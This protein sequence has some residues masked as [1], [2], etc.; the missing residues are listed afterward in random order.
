MVS[1]A[2]PVASEKDLQAIYFTSNAGVVIIFSYLVLFLKE[3]GIS[4]TE[5]GY[6]AVSFSFAML[7]SNTLFGRLSDSKG[8]RPFLLSGLLA[9]SLS[10][11]L[12]IF[13]TTL[14]G[15]FLA[16][17]LN[18]ISLGIFPASIVGVAS[19]RSLK[20]GKL[21]AYGSIGWA[22]GGLIGGFLAEVMGLDWLFVASAVLYMIAFLI[23]MTSGTGES[24]VP[25]ETV[26]H[27]NPREMYMKALRKNWVIYL[28]FVM[29]HGTANS[30]WIFWALFL[31]EDLQ[32]TTSQ[33][34]IVQAT[35]MITQFV[36]MRTVTD[37][38]NPRLMVILGGFTSAL[39][40]WTFTI[41]G[42]FTQIVLSQVILGFSWAMFYV[43]GLRTVEMRSR[44]EGIVA[45]G[46]GLFNASL[47]VSQLVGPFLAIYLYS[48][49]ST[50]ILSMNVA[51]LVTAVATILF[52]IGTV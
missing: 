6:L 50:Y 1:S 31:S 46:T 2:Q 18:G 45:T 13:P 47:S 27:E 20:L 3:R 7:L 26:V 36:F 49:S 19:D 39:A 29:R 28:L 8:R 24:F 9:A 5:I 21:T 4:E 38:M 32:L 11:L 14:G 10:S 48:V 35:N 22:T 17:M 33:I 42:D 40:F 51:A 30:I 23:V 41:A 12:Y 34:G 43:G 16:R 44:D 52:V 37:K 25:A 15:F